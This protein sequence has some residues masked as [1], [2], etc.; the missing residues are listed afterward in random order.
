MLKGLFIII[1]IFWAYFSFLILPTAFF[2]QAECL[3]NG[4]PTYVVTIGLERYCTTLDGAVI[5]EVKKL[6]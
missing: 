4:Y 2:T 3:R 1:F 5:V 6:D